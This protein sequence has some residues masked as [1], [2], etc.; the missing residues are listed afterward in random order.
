[1]TARGMKLE[2]ADDNG[3]RLFRAQPLN[4]LQKEMLLMEEFED[5]SPKYLRQC[6]QLTIGIILGAIKENGEISNSQG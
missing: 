4:F 2:A 5:K 1:M 6:A 3:R